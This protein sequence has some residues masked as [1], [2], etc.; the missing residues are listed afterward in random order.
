METVLLA[1][2]LARNSLTDRSSASPVPREEQRDQDNPNPEGE[3][4]L[5]PLPGVRMR[6]GAGVTGQSWYPG[7]GQGL[8][9][10]SMLELPAL[11]Q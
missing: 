5:R 8:G 2:L 7:L 11:T 3:Q 1:G 4:E 6:R 9:W 10:L